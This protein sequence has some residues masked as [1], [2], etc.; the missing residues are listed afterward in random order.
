MNYWTHYDP[1]LASSAAAG[2]NSMLSGDWSAPDSA[3][4]RNIQAVM[5]LKGILVGY[6]CGVVTNTTD[7]NGEMTTTVDADV[8]SSVGERGDCARA[9]LAPLNVYALDAKIG[10]MPAGDLS[11]VAPA[12]T[13]LW[14]L[15]VI[16]VVAAGAVLL[17]GWIAHE[18]SSV[19]K[20]WHAV[21]AQRDQLQQDD[22]KLTQL[23]ADHVQ[24]EQ[25]AGKTLPLDPAVQVQ[26]AAVVK[27]TDDLTAALKN[28][29][30]DAQA[31]TSILPWY[32][33]AGIGVGGAL[34]LALILRQ[35][36]GGVTVIREPA[37]KAA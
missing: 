1:N 37:Q 15:A 29:N 12:D 13:G 22:A 10:P 5:A 17:G 24:K 26:M 14:P 21:N 23:V 32:A 30:P 25:A 11:T 8:L 20:A 27:R 36:G 7:P 18:A 19:V 34:V 28:A 9:L 6:L 31:S 4:V 3:N 35:S 2:L 16:A 33:W